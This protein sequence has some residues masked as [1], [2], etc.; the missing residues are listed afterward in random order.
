MESATLGSRCKKCRDLSMA[1][2]QERFDGLFY[3]SKTFK[4]LDAS[5]A[6]GCPLCQI[7]RR[8]LVF[9]ARDIEEIQIGT[10][11]EV[12]SLNSSSERP[13]S[14]AVF[15]EDSEDGRFM[16]TFY[17]ARYATIEPIRRKCEYLSIRA[18][19]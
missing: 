4:Q 12:T 2:N 5:A 3:H 9:S 14:L 6:A 17:P 8:V 1:V 10:K 11:I 18:K 15:M 7:L 19:V 13:K 16:G